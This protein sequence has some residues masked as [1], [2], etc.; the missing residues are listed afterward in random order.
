MLTNELWSKVFKIDVRFWYGALNLERLKL[1]QDIITFKYCVFQEMYFV[2]CVQIFINF[3]KTV[4]LRRVSL[5]N[6]LFI[7]VLARTNQK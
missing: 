1:K 6:P 2:E 7:S 4:T 3:D 5:K